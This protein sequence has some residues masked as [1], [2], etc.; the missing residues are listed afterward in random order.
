MTYSR[1]LHF[2]RQFVTRW[3]C[4][5]VYLC[6]RAISVSLRMLEF[7]LAAAALLGL[8]GCQSRLQDDAVSIGQEPGA[9]DQETAADASDSPPFGY[10]PQMA[11]DFTDAESVTGVGDE[12]LVVGV[13]VQGQSRA[14]P[15]RL[16]AHGEH[17]NDSIGAE[18]VCATW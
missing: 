6:S 2:V 3:A 13:F 1:Q 16:L 4:F 12:E 11:G 14:Y 8:L 7:A 17:L 18:P 15:L 10:P 5:E 9:I